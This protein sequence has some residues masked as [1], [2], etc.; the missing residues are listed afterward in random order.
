MGKRRQ[1]QAYTDPLNMLYKIETNLYSVMDEHQRA[2]AKSM[3]TT[4]VTFCDAKSG[5]GKTTIAVMVALEGLSKKEFQN[6]IYMFDMSTTA[7]SRKDAGKCNPGR[8][9]TWPVSTIPRCFDGT[10]DFGIS[11]H[12]VKE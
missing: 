12:S 3:Q 1:E 8:E 5:T 9:R 10:R 6:I 7:S 2:Y 11:V 4:P